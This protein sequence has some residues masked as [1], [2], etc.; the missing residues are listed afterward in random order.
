MLGAHF[1]SK[2][3][4]RSHPKSKSY[5][6]EDAMDD[7]MHMLQVSTDEA[8]P[9]GGVTAIA[10]G[11]PALQAA[12]LSH[13]DVLRVLHMGQ[14]VSGTVLGRGLDLGLGQQVRQEV[15]CGGGE[16]RDEE[17]DVAAES[18]P[19]LA[20]LP[21]TVQ[22]PTAHNTT[23][24]SSATNSSSTN[25]NEAGLPPPLSKELLRQTAKDMERDRL[26]LNGQL[27]VG[28][29]R[30]LA[31]IAAQVR[32]LVE[33]AL[34]A[35]N[36][37]LLDTH[38]H[39]RAVGIG[40]PRKKSEEEAAA[41]AETGA[42]ADADA[43]TERSQAYVDALLTNLVQRCLAKASR[44]NSG[45]SSYLALQEALALGPDSQLQLLPLSDLATPLCVRVGVCALPLH[46]AAI[47]GDA[48][49]VSSSHSSG[50]DN[51]NSNSD[52]K[53]TAHSTDLA[54]V[55]QI[56]CATFFRV[57]PLDLMGM[58]MDDGAEEEEGSNASASASASAAPKEVQAYSVKVSY[59]DSVFVRIRHHSLSVREKASVA[60]TSTSVSLFVPV[61][62]SVVE[63]GAQSVMIER[64]VP[65]L[66][67]T[68]PARSGLYS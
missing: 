3:G 49:A 31:C 39:S 12:L 50:N 57:Q 24:T 38:T 9:S 61:L 41:E 68:L 47:C 26:L 63:D 59:T 16:D 66:E 56:D 18:V 37:A 4:M 15:R 20:S 35:Y 51:S 14:D 21:R 54:I 34:L 23:T 1:A 48:A 44:T 67:A 32:A 5:T 29:E 27:V 30:G 42:E 52:G 58:V 43:G 46:A 11:D 64:F 40:E 13:F 53:A 8:F 10:V 6:A 65:P 33:Q 62:G 55:C 25:G 60:S 22:L 7:A 36:H 17:G 2:L 19:F 28:A 45:G